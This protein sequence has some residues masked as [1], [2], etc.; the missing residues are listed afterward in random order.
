MATNSASTQARVPTGQYIV[1]MCFRVTYSD[2]GIASGVPVPGKLLPAGAIIVG[3]D[4]VVA[5]TFNAQTTNVLTVG[6]NGTTAN[7]I[8][9]SADVDETTAGLTKNVSPT[10][11]ALGRIASDSQVYVKYTQ[12]GTAASQGVADIIIKYVYPLNDA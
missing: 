5:T 11:T 8:I 3:T 4:A 9:A 7:N 10:G 6:I 1:P 2:A 12:T